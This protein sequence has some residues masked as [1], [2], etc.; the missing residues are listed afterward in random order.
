MTA[1]QCPARNDNL[2]SAVANG[3]AHTP[4]KPPPTEIVDAIAAIR[5]AMVGR[6]GQGGYRGDASDE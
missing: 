3:T 5:S 2:R 4:Y 1:P 6:S